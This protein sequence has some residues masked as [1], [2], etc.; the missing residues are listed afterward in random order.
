[1]K[2]QP[3]NRLAPDREQILTE[4]LNAGTATRVE[5]ILDN[6]GIRLERSG[7]DPLQIQAFW[8]HLHSDL[9]PAALTE[10][11]NLAFHR[12]VG[13]TRASILARAKR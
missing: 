6:A 3:D 10:P 9:D 2:D 5:V 7:L 12:L 11:S 8:Q 4:L 1:V 13:Y